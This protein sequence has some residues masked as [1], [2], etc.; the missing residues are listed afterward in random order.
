[1]SMLNKLNYDTLETIGRYLTDID[2]E[3]LQVIKKSALIRSIITPMISKIQFN[4][5]N[6]KLNRLY[7]REINDI[8][9]R[10]KFE[11]LDQIST[12]ALNLKNVIVCGDICRPRCHATGEAIFK[13]PNVCVVCILPSTSIQDN[14]IKHL[15]KT[16][17]LQICHLKKITV[18]AF[19]PLSNLK[20]LDISSCHSIQR[21]D[22]IDFCNTRCIEVDF[23]PDPEL[24]WPLNQIDEWEAWE[25]WAEQQD[26]DDYDAW[27]EG[28]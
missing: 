23:D 4:A 8:Q 19:K 24:D 15:N 16:E 10:E 20:I 18:D 1:M 6:L 13:I 28:T 2:I 17:I 7:W 11:L 9:C 25:I 27:L 21:G 26:D 14:D 12:V 22:L 5:D 3:Q